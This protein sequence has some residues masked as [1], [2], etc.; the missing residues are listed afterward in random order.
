M[1]K[2]TKKITFA[3]SLFSLALLSCSSPTKEEVVSE[4][5]EDSESSYSWEES[6]EAQ[7]IESYSIEEYSEE[8]ETSFHFEDNATLVRSLSS[9]AYDGELKKEKTY[10]LPTHFFSL[11]ED[12]PYIALKTFFEGFVNAHFTGGRRLFEVQGERVINLESEVEMLFSLEDNSISTPDLSSFLSL[13]GQKNLTSDL[14][15]VEEDSTARIHY[16]TCSSTKGEETLFK[17]DRYGAKLVS[18]RNKIYAP[19]AFLENLILA[20]FPS[21]FAWNGSDY[22]AISDESLFD[23]LEELTPYGRAFY[24]GPL[25]K[26]DKRSESFSAYF[27]GSFLFQMESYNGKLKEKG[28]SDLDATLEEKGLKKKLL[29]SDSDIADEAV[30]QAVNELFYDGGH[31]SFHHR[32]VSCSFDNM[33]DINLSSALGEYDE[34][35][36]KSIIKQFALRKLR[37]GQENSL[38]M[39]GSTASIRLDSFSLNKEGKAP[40]L[41]DVASDSEST[42]AILYNSFK[43]IEKNSSIKNVV[44]DVSLNGGGQSPALGEALGFLTNED[45][46]MK[47]T[48]P[49]DLSTCVESVRYDTDLDGDFTDDDSY[50]GKY[51][52]YILTSSCSFSCANAFPCLA[53]EKGLAKIIGE[54][55]GG[56]DCAVGLGVLADGTYFQMSSYRSITR[57]NG[58]SVD[59]GQAL[60]YE[61]DSSYFYDIAKLDSYFSSLN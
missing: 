32:G 7:T 38:C 30:A 48:N 44:I 42:F 4:S 36:E 8:E 11:A 53:K 57:E 27:Y 19:F 16:A 59:D 47:T 54:R 52:F 26:L 18:C 46:S 60:D 9:R 10:S 15:A 5:Y 49:L 33:K 25:S 17:L 3:L 20:E 58:Q 24:E 55:S 1:K 2:Q 51:D 28:I 56:G 35:W 61:L 29:S 14:L 40:T 39:S 37:K 13:T 23:S 21:R 12:V 31:T 43:E 6:E 50:E 22:F 45:V 41:S 34:R